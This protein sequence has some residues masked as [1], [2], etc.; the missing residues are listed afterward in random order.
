MCDAREKRLEAWVEGRG[1]EKGFSGAGQKQVLIVKNQLVLVFTDVHMCAHI[2]TL[3]IPVC[4][5][6]DSRHNDNL[7]RR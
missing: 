1:G 6:Q 4:P 5:P 7:V 3:L 2:N